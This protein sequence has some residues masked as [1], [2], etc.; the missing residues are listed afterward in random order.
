MENRNDDINYKAMFSESST[1]V[2]CPQTAVE[3]NVNQAK[4]NQTPEEFVIDDNI[5]HTQESA[6]LD[7]TSQ[8]RVEEDQ[9]VMDK[10]AITV[11]PLVGM[12]CQGEITIEHTRI[13][14]GV[15]GVNL[16]M[17]MGTQETVADIKSMAIHDETT[18][19]QIAANQILNA[20]DNTGMVHIS[21]DDDIV[22]NDDDKNVKERRSERLKKYTNIHTMNKATKMAQKC[23][24][25]GN[26]KN[27]NSLSLFLLRKL[28]LFM[29]IWV[30]LLTMM[31]LILLLC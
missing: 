18:Q 24:L 8:E 27:Q 26:S 25:E 4:I 13:D 15:T 21:S 30:L 7:M 6:D 20:D 23:N 22:A 2:F 5:I 14:N 10:E 16:D 19:D 17:V 1:D 28:L 12:A 11:V 31:I 29:L 3:S 9:I